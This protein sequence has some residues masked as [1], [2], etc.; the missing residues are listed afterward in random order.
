M[1]HHPVGPYRQLFPQRHIPIILQL[2][3][4]VG[5]EI[6]KKTANDLEDRISLRLYRRLIHE[7]IFRDGPLQ[8]DLQTSVV[9]SET[10]ADEENLEGR[11]DL[12][13]SCSLGYETYFAIEAKRLRVSLP[14][15]FFS[16]GREYVEDGMMRFVTGQYAPFMHSGAMLGYVYD[17]D[18]DSAR[19]DIDRQVQIRAQALKLKKPK[20]LKP[21][22][23]LSD[24]AVDETVHNLDKRHFTIYHLLLSV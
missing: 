15:R 10:D 18:K 8:I 11:L 22:T 16:G 6:R 17:G 24:Y 13:V 9:N 12:K 2:I 4:E 19:E 3:F 21:S 20:N 14:S 7:P 5:K 23:T 1:T